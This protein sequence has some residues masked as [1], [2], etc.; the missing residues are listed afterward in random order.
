[1]KVYIAQTRLPLVRRSGLEPAYGKK[2][3]AAWKAEF[4]VDRYLLILRAKTLLTQAPLSLQE[5]YS[6]RLR[7]ISTKTM[8]CRPYSTVRGETKEGILVK[9]I[10]LLLCVLDHFLL[11]VFPLLWASNIS[12]PFEGRTGNV[13]ASH[14]RRAAAP[15]PGEGYPRGLG[16]TFLLP[17]THH[18]PML[19]SALLWQLTRLARKP[20]QAFFWIANSAV[21]RVFLRVTAVLYLMWMESRSAPT[22]FGV[23]HAVGSG[24]PKACTPWHG[25]DIFK[26]D[27]SYCTRSWLG[28]LPNIVCFG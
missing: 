4:R 7:S 1:M 27:R 6:R 22:W 23:H 12:I 9:S 24:Y 13:S 20:Q 16:K 28:Q 8:V 25:K 26:S 10:L 2:L 19:L 17:C 3:S 18:S 14:G 21:M 15:D 5:R 11:A